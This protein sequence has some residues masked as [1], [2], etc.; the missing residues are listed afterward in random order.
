MC[1]ERLDRVWVEDEERET[2][3]EEAAL[4]KG[5]LRLYKLMRDVAE[6]LKQLHTDGQ[7]VSQTDWD[8]QQ[9]KTTAPKKNKKTE[10]NILI[11]FEMTW[12]EVGILFYCTAV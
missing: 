11:E 8:A 6:T 2:E 5:P 12:R 9:K 3:R 7:A 1:K 4:I 10:D